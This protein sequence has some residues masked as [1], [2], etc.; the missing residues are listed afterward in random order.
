MSMTMTL[1]ND[2]REQTLSMISNMSERDAKVMYTFAMDFLSN[3]RKNP[4][5][6]LSSDEIKQDLELSTQQFKNGQSTDAK[7]VHQR[8]R[9][10][11]GL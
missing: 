2:Y 11:H 3:D 8:I 10:R 1:P 7:T 6:P 5:C 9:E 4:F